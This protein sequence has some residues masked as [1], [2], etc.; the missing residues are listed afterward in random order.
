M[1]KENEQVVNP[2]TEIDAIDDELLR[3]LN[4]RADIALQVGKLKTQGDASL[5]DQNREREV[6]SRLSHK[7]TGP[8]DDQSIYEIFQRIIDE[9]LHLQ[10]TFY[11][12]AVDTDD[13]V[14]NTVIGFTE[15]SRIAF[16]GEPGTFS[17]E[18]AIAILGEGGQTI[19]R[20][21][22]DD[23]FR[24]I[25]EGLADYI[26]TPLENSLVGSIHR[27]YDLLLDSKLT[28]VAEVVT[29]IFHYLIGA[30]NAT[31]ERVRTVESHPAALAQCETFFAAHPDL[32]RV[33]ANDTAGSVRHVVESGDL[34]RAAI[35]S[36]RAAENYRGRILREHIEDH[37][38]NFTRFVLLSNGAP[39]KEGEK[40]SLVVK[41]KHQPGALHRALRPIVRRGINLLKIESRPIRGLPSEFNFYFDLEAPARE[42]ELDSAL[43]EIRA[44]ADE[45]RLLGRYKVVRIAGGR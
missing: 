14:N 33:P 37:S 38:E 27:S 45:V 8:F 16:F 34:T 40:I 19:S 35:G 26:L 17:E 22:F 32:V 31:F 6:L 7:N 36:R 30:E 10:Q 1:T 5:C 44:S 4:K 15:R 9:S 21:A 25:E 12:K 3:L 23:L 13:H 18:A 11:H 20:P 43:D 41:L 2:R 42:I 29:P 39:R 24:S 28:I